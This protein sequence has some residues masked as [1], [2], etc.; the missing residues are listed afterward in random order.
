MD[1]SIGVSAD[2][3][4]VAVGGN[5]LWGLMNPMVEKKII[6]VRDVENNRWH[7]GWML[8]TIAA[9][10]AVFVHHRGLVWLGWLYWLISCN[11]KKSGETKTYKFSRQVCMHAQ[12]MQNCRQLQM[13]SVLNGWMGLNKTWHTNSCSFPTSIPFFLLL[14]KSWTN[15]R[16]WDWLT[17]WCRVP[18]ESL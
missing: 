11:N 17:R 3:K 14:Y 1:V 13:H 6:R 8:W 10:L 15:Q 4:R 16:P 5:E 12:K 9:V 7:C 18:V 2:G